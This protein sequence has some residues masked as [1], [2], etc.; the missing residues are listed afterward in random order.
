VCLVGKVEGTKIQKKYYFCNFFLDIKN[1]LYNLEIMHN[2]FLHFL[3]DV[4]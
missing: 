1:R 3:F 2:L 4:L